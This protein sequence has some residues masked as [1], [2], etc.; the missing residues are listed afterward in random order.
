MYKKFAVVVTIVCGLT[1]V[2]AGMCPA[3]KKPQPQAKAKTPDIIAA[4]RAGDL[5][6]VKAIVK[7]NPAAVKAVDKRRGGT[8]LHWAAF[9][10]HKDV[11]LFLIKSGADVNASAGRSKVTPLHLAAGSRRGRGTAV[12][13]ALLAKGAKVGAI[14]RRKRTVLHYAA[15]RGRADVV[16][17]LLA[18]GAE[19]DAKDYKKKTPLHLAAYK[20]RTAAVKLLLD[21]GAKIEAL[22][23]KGR[24]PLNHAVQRK[25]V[26]VV[27]LLLDKGANPNAKDYKGRSLLKIAKRRNNQEVIDLLVKKGAQE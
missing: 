1:L 9:R 17:M 8:A 6:A 23:Y 10:G 12:V 11:A 7:D 3:H 2:M 20:G 27:K 13:A 19:A 22:D 25:R 4:A 18:K 21:K 24:T 26:A 16:K 15:Y 5:K 14:D